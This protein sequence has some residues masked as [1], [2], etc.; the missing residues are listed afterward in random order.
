VPGPVLHMGSYW[1]PV[2]DGVPEIGEHTE[3]G[4]TGLLGLS[5]DELQA[6]G[7]AAVIGPTRVPA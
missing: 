6:L 4:L 2:Y 5:A 7:A 1:G 3:P